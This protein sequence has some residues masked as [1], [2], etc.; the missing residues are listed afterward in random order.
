MKFKRLIFTVLLLLL[1]GGASFAYWRMGNSNKEPPFLTVP[2]AKSNVRQMVSSTGTLQAVTT[3]IVGS[4][5]SGTI[6]KLSADFNSKV[7]K[8][9]VVA[10][11]DQS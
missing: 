9:Q 5:V 1:V 10:E 7:T 6:A 8:G 11:L 4:Q 3:V 2:V